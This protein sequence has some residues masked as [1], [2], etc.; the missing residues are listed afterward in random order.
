[1]RADWVLSK[2]LAIMV[3]RHHRFQFRALSVYLCYLTSAAEILPIFKD[4]SAGGREWP[5]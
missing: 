1:M 4:R 5:I 2:A 3:A